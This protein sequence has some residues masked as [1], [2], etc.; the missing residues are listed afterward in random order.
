VQKRGRKRELIIA[1]YIRTAIRKGDCIISRV[2]T[3]SVFQRD[4]GQQK[5]LASSHPEKLQ[6]MI[7][8]FKKYLERVMG[9]RRYLGVEIER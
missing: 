6:E 9:R 7:T 2:L 1:A 5:N 8:L 3:Y 4:I